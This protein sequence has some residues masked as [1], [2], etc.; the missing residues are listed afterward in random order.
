[1][2]G[3]SKAARI[4]QIAMGFVYLIAGAIKV[5]EP[6]LFYW[7]SIPYMQILGI[8]RDNW[9]SVTA[10]AKVTTVLGPI[11]FT[12]GLALMLNWRPHISL[13]VAAVLMA[14]FSGLMIK[15]WHM[16]ASIDC[17]CFGALVERSPGEAAVED[18]VMLVILAFSWWGMLR[19]GVKPQMAAGA[20]VYG[21]AQMATGANW[22]GIGGMPALR[23]T[24]GVVL[25]ALAVSLIVWGGR[26]LPEMERIQLSDLKAGVRLTG[27][28]LKGVEIDLL[29]GEYLLEVFSPTCGHCMD[30][31]P[32]I[33]GMADDPDLPR[34]I[35][36]TSFPQDSPQLAEFKERL[37]PHFDIATISQ[38]DYYR[39]TF[40]HGYPR[41]AYIKDGEVVSVWE[42]DFMPTASRLKEITGP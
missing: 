3:V 24:N 28:N 11:E 13:P 16:G 15:A 23:Q 10:A 42:R 5:W 30:A 17:G 37:Q 35:A 31:V 39:L 14:L 25:G 33:N 7:E 12:L 19:G 36:L 8:G 6:V 18:V 34:V 9:E 26:F 32:K 4:G 29:E 41:L 1:M 2:N 21:N 27:L 22:W 38:T 20:R 40:G